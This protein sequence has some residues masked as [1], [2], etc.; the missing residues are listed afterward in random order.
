MKLE[1][2]GYNEQVEKRRDDHHLKD[3]DIGRVVAEHKERYTVI[4]EKGNMMPK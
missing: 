4:T 3:F 2:F 1:D